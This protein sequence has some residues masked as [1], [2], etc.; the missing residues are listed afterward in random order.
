[1]MAIC[2][3]ASIALIIGILSPSKVSNNYWSWLIILLCP[4][5]HILMMGG[6]VGHNSCEHEK[7]DPLYQCPECGFEYRE[8]IW[9][10]KC[11]A[12]CKEYKSCNLEVTKR[13]V[14][15]SI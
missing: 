13:A 9:A 6:H 4:L 2:C 8:K 5:M 3:L 12:W 1:M 10:E 15:G 7:N 14:K 11:E